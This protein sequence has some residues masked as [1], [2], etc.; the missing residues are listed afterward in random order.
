MN[1]VPL[2]KEFWIWMSLLTLFSLSTGRDKGPGSRVECSAKI[3]MF[4]ICPFF[5]FIWS[6][7]LF[8]ERWEPWVTLIIF[9]KVK[10]SLLSLWYTDQLITLQLFFVAFYLYFYFVEFAHSQLKNKIVSFLILLKKFYMYYMYVFCW[11]CTF[12]IKK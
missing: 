4:F 6:V 3:S 5:F 9:W 1:L 12:A 7:Y 8:S 10:S 2:G 11:I